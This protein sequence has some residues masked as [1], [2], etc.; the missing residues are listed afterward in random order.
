MPY[1]KTGGTML[2]SLKLQPKAGKT[3]LLHSDLIEEINKIEGLN[4][5]D[6]N[7]GR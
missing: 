7:L 4:Y 2:S 6:E 1:L 3:N 5:I